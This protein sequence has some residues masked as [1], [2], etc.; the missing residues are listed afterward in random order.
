MTGR[1]VAVFA[2]QTLLKKKKNGYTLN[3]GGSET[4]VCI[5][6]DTKFGT[7]KIPEDITGFCKGTA[8]NDV[9]S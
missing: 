4:V 1:G 9:Q 2:E 5:P 3:T 7:L 8:G 6:I